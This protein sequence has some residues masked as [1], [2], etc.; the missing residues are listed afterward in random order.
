VHRVRLRLLI[1][2]ARTLGIGADW[3]LFYRDSK[4]SLELLRD[5]TQRNPVARLYLAWDLGYTRKRAERAAGV[6]AD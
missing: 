2:V 3:E 4:Y 5:R 1:P 6:T